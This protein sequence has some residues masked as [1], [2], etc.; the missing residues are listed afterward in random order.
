M[1]VGWQYLNSNWYYL[2]PVSDGTRGAMKT[3]YQKVGGVWY[4]L[5]PG[6]G[7]LWVNRT[8]PNGSVADSSGV[9]H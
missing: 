2:N 6:S 3:G 4:Y 8:V 7:V 1:K 5:D 9:L